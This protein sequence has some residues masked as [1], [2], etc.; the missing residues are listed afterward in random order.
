M[1]NWKFCLAILT[2][3]VVLMSSS[4]TMLI[5]FL[6]MY[7]S[8]DLGAD[9]GAVNMWSGIVFSSSFAVS[10][11]MAPIWG[12]MADT[13]G[14][15]LMAI[16]ASF[17]LAV[18]Y[19]L[20]GIVQTPFQL[21]LMRLFQGFAAGLWP[22]DLAIMT[23][24]A[25]KDK[26]GFCLGVMQG[27]LTSGVVIGPLLGGILAE[28][29]GM[30][31]SFFIAAGALMLNFFAFVFL[32]KEP[33]PTGEPTSTTTEQTTTKPPSLWKKPIIRDMLIY[34]V[35]VQMVILLVQPIMTTYVEELS[36]TTENILFI[37]GLVFSLSGFSSAIAAP[38][39]GKFGQRSGFR[40]SL[41]WALTAAGIVGIVQSMP[42]TLY[43]FA[44]AQFAIG[45]FFSGIYPSINAILAQ[46]TDSRAKAKVFGLLF[47]AQQIG[48]MAGPLLGGVIATVVGMKYVF[49]VA[50]CIL[51]A[52]SISVRLRK[53][54]HT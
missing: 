16:R 35:F 26:L 47:S 30:R 45:L 38:L 22:M 15:R 2:C 50:G 17:L 40:R 5:P 19:F 46:N 32:I 52:I 14:K 31:P 1:M 25:P 3:N 37:S 29:F 27:A 18:S 13:K 33:K 8:H 39:W 24:V 20:G 49:L 44:T 48:S 41:T 12:K 51:L 4:Y 6:P 10:A 21:V 43:P 28:V 7:L 34:G 23:T 11:I 36:G 54:Q 42:N 9:P 53:Y